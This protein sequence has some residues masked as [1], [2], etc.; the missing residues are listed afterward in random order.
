MH[1]QNTDSQTAMTKVGWIINSRPIAPITLGPRAWELLTLSHLILLKASLN[2]P[3]GIFDHKDC[4][5][6]RLWESR[7]PA[8]FKPPTKVVPTATQCTKGRCSSIS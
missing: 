7:V 8:Q 5:V 2:V 6:W 3:T 1:A 4:N